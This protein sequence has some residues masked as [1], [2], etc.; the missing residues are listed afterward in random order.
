MYSRGQGVRELERY[1]AININLRCA[2]NPT[3]HLLLQYFSLIFA[4][5]DA[6]V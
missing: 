4:F 1:R 5:K 3:I 6:N 2:L